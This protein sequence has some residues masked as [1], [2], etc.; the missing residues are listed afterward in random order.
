MKSAAAYQERFDIQ[1]EL[2]EGGF[3]RVFLARE[4]NT[5]RKVALKVLKDAYLKDSEVV[6]RFRREVFAVASISSPHVVGMHDFGISGDEVYIAMEFVEGPTLRDLIYERAWTVNEVH[7]IIG[8]IAQAL[9]AAHRQDIVH[10][11]LKPENVILVQGNDGSR[12]VKVLDFGLAKIADL[13]RK[14]GLEP[15][16]RAGMCFGTPQYMAPEL[17]RGKPFDRS[18]DLYALAVI[19]FEMIAGFLPWDG[20]DPREVLISVVKNP[21]PHLSH[22]HPSIDR[23]AE[24][25][26]FLQRTLSKD[27]AERPRDAA[28]FFRDFERALFGDNKPKRVNVQVPKEDAVFATVWAASLDLR[29]GEDATEIDGMG[30]RV[31]T[32]EATNEFTRPGGSSNSKRKLASGWM[33]NLTDVETG[34]THEDLSV[35][36]L[37]VMDA[38]PKPKPNPV[39]VFGTETI[40][41]RANTVERP[42][43]VKKKK[44]K[45]TSED[46]EADTVERSR[47]ARGTPTPTQPVNQPLGNTSLF[48]SAGSKT[49]HTQMIKAPARSMLWWVV[50]L[51]LGLVV[52]AAALGYVMGGR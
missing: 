29:R 7:L 34:D 6:E 15:L 21:P 1:K 23:I 33:K 13:E 41:E 36:A 49:D 50:P 47:P 51:L 42:R 39:P 37:R 8:Q 20:I 46:E 16:T 10:R 4:K 31:H 12:R 35:A 9:S 26:T 52:F 19:A 17:I 32:P 44:K 18:V 5:Q 3:A 2:G 24:V 30:N 45:K 25:D 48:G 27:A 38:S 43:V 22:A 11:D 28:Q 40:D 14:L